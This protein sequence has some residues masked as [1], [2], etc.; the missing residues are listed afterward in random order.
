[1]ADYKKLYFEM[2]NNLTNVIESL[3]EIQQ[4]AEEHY[5]EIEEKETNQ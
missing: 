4:N 5:I 2:F 1:M 3:K